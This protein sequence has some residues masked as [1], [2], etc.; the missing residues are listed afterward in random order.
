MT[1][2]RRTWARW[3]AGLTLVASLAPAAFAADEAP[4]ALIKRLSDEMLALIR[5]D[6]AIRVRIGGLVVARQRPGTASGVCFM[7]LEDEHGHVNLV[8]HPDVYERHRA[9]VRGE[10]LLLEA[11]HVPAQDVWLSFGCD[12]E[13]SGTAASA[14][15]P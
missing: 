13:V 14:A 3:L 10:P 5:S 9:I 15:P 4:D 8:V 6:A 7:L 11:G 2:N 1:M 12:E